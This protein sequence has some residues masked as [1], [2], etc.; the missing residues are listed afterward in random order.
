MRGRSSARALELEALGLPFAPIARPDELFNDP[1]LIESGGLVALTLP[2]GTATALP[3]LPI[4]IDGARMT[5]RHDVP[6]VDQDAAHIL[7][8]L[9]ESR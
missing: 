7:S 5:L 4:E 1:H 6:K 2:D 8:E 3:G 9:S